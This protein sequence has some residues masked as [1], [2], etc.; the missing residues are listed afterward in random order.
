MGRKRLAPRTNYLSLRGRSA[1]PRRTRYLVV[2]PRRNLGA[3]GSSLAYVR[4]DSKKTHDERSNSEDI[5]RRKSKQIPLNGRQELQ[6][7]A[8]LYTVQSLPGA[9]EAT[10]FAS[11]IGTSNH[12]QT[13]TGLSVDVCRE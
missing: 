8:L 10:C 7:R 3:S 13:G 5:T 11:S 12:T 4:T 1:G 9:G 6:F 2:L